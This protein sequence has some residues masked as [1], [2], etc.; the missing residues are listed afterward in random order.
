MMWIL[1]VVPM[2]MILSARKNGRL[3]YFEFAYLREVFLNIFLY[4][5][6]YCYFAEDVKPPLVSGYVTIAHLYNQD[7]CTYFL[8]QVTSLGAAFIIF[9]SFY[10]HF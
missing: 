10:R 4:N 3:K 1:I 9:C 2:T 8:L 6:N 5:L 7:D